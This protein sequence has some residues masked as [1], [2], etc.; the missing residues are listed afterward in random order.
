MY[1]R[2]ERYRGIRRAI[3]EVTGL[4]PCELSSRVSCQFWSRGEG[5]CFAD[6]DELPDRCRDRFEDEEDE[7]DG[8]EPMASGRVVRTRPCGG[9]PRTHRG[10]QLA[11][12]VRS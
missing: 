2:D 9:D 8:L 7:D 4:R 11:P 12:Q 3:A 5:K 10:S 1:G 6:D